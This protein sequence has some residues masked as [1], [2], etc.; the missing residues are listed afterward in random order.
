M[1]FKW[2]KGK[3]TKRLVKVLYI[4]KGRDVKGEHFYPEVKMDDWIHARNNFPLL[5]K[6][7]STSRRVF[8]LQKKKKMT[9]ATLLFDSF[10]RDVISKFSV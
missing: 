7:N 9:S 3:N 8:R 10:P 1:V 6:L 2:G 4:Q 5:L